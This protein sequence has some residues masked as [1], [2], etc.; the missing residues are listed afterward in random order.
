MLK[1]RREILCDLGRVAAA[2][3]AAP[4]VSRLT[5]AEPETR[6]E[7]DVRGATADS[8]IFIWLGGGASHV[9]TWDPKRRGDAK[10]G[11]PGSDYD[12][13]P[14]VVDGVAVCEHL[15]RMA[16]LL[17]RAILFRTVHHDVIDEHAAAV[18]RVHT[19]RP[20]TG[21]TIY[22]SIGSV[23]AK[24]LGP[25]G[26]GVPAYVV[27]GYPSAS[28]GPG[29][30]GAQSGYVYLT[31]TE[32]GPAGLK[33]PVEVS[34]QR[35]QR[36]EKLLTPLRDRFL[37][38]NAGQE[39]IT[40]YVATSAQGFRLAGPNFMSVFDLKSES[41]ALRNAYGGEFGQRC[42]M[43]RR[44][45]EAGVRFVEVSFNLNFINGTGWDTHNE[46][47]LNQ[48]VLIDQLDQALAALIVDLEQRKRLDQTLIVVA[49]EFGRPPEFDGGG[50]RGHYSKAFSMIT[51]GGGLKN[52]QA[53]GVTDELG[54][55]IL[56]M[57][58][59]VP[60]FHATIYTALGI[61]PSEEIYDGV[62]PVPITD[63]GRPVSQAFA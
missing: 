14:T 16:K 22:P 4:W 50:G 51:A 10:A 37:Q 26:E 54:K 17:D 27:M 47:Q 15:P 21:T 33:R 35:Q 42:L 34:D 24:Q 40:D 57:P 5:A 20:P 18:N 62:R 61:N 46:G 58:V 19:G 9:D 6:P 3:G 60:D 48:H 49:T 23:V 12:S 25:R 45:I 63:H 28:R 29:F 39:K 59:S 13:I 38:Q 30:L 53:I 1:N 44:L 43:S 32:L 41:D 2:A 7:R 56:E 36:R 31:D 8:C 52:G 11:K 55:Q